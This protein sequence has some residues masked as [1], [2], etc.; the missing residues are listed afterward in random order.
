MRNIKGLIK[1]YMILI[2]FTFFLLFHG[3]VNENQ[4]LAS[5]IGL[6]SFTMEYDLQN[7]LMSVTDIFYSYENAIKQRNSFPTLITATGIF[8]L[9]LRF[10]GN[11]N[12]GYGFLARKVGWLSASGETA[13]FYRDASDPNFTNQKLYNLG[14]NYEDYSFIGL[15]QQKRL[16]TGRV[17]CVLEEDF[18]ICFDYHKFKATGYGLLTLGTDGKRKINIFGSYEQ[19]GIDKDKVLGWGGS[20]SWQA[21]AK[22]SPKTEFYLKVRNLPGIIYFPSLTL[23][24]GNVDSSRESI[25][26]IAIDGFIRNNSMVLIMPLEIQGSLLFQMFNG[27]VE[28]QVLSISDVYNISIGY[29][30]P[31]HE[32]W[33]MEMALNPV[34]YQLS[35]ECV[36]PRGK[37]KIIADPQNNWTIGGVIITLKI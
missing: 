5:E 34:N 18:F 4:V 6:D 19:S 33:E 32:R 23:E 1:Y 24:N 26:P 30:Y 20:L 9:Q 13:Q 3:F 31:L 14:M 28:L 17:E 7:N 37:F 16:K 25:G 12:I 22:L 29:L 11:D 8:N 36:F 10:G 21:K 2:F 15:Y 35:A 27:K